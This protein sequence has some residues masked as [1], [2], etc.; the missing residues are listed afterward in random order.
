MHSNILSLPPLMR[1]HTTSR[2]VQRSNVRRHTFGHAQLHIN[3]MRSNRIQVQHTLLNISTD[4]LP[5]CPHN[6]LL[7]I[8]HNVTSSQI[9]TT[10]YNPR[11][12]KFTALIIN[13]SHI[14][15]IRS[16]LHK[17]MILFR[18][19]NL[20]IKR[21]LLRVL[22]ITSIHTTRHVS[23]LIKITS[24]NS[25]YQTNPPHQKNIQRSLP[26]HIRTHRL[27]SRL[28][29]N[30]IHILMFI[31]RS[32]ARLVAMV[33]NRLQLNTRRFSHPT[34]R[35]IRVSNIHRN[36]AVLM[37]NM[38]S[39]VR[40]LSIT[41]VTSLVATLTKSMIKHMTLRLLLPASR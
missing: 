11:L 40:R 1:P 22:S 25:P 41:R 34:S 10:R 32:V 36:R 5:H 24:S 16:N 17:T 13:S 7:N 31:S 8:I 35:V 19:S 2:L 38:S 29:L 21:V 26:N 14:N 39:K 6:L 20:H 3:A 28:M 30:V 12:L 15:H 27:T 9:P 33:I 18:R 37:F 23:Q 4:S